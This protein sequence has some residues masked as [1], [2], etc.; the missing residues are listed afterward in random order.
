VSERRQAYDGMDAGWPD[1]L[2]GTGAA[3]GTAEVIGG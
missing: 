1:V 3:L 2:A